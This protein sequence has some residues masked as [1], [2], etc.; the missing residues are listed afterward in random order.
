MSSCS[1]CGTLRQSREWYPPCRRAWWCFAVLWCAVSIL[2]WYPYG[3][4]LS[5]AGQGLVQGFGNSSPDVLL[6]LFSLQAGHHRI[7]FV[8][9]LVCWFVGLSVCWFVGLL[10]CWFVGLF[11]LFVL[12]VCLF[13]CF[14]C[15]FVLFV[16]FFLFVCLFC[17]VGWLF[18]CLFC[19][20]GWLVVCLFVY[21]VGWLVVWICLVCLFVCNCEPF[22]TPYEHA[23]G[24][25]LWTH[26]N[27]RVEWI[28]WQVKISDLQ[29]QS[30]LLTCFF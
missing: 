6:S 20:V 29:P 14:V 22:V 7:W 27:A 9:L 1:A 5:H 8:G 3:S 28:A 10:V 15:L 16:L 18:V 17:L 12:F 24:K 30:E 13:V 11:V 26:L 21:L 2:I 19:L 25:I 4:M 23:E